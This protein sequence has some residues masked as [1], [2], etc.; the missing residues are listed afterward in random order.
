MT[1]LKSFLTYLLLVISVVSLAQNKQEMSLQAFNKVNLQGIM[2]VELVK[3]AANKVTAEALNG[4]NIEDLTVSVAG[5]ELSVKTKIFKQLTDK[6]QKKNNKANKE[7]KVK[8]EYTGDLTVLSA[9]RGADV[10][11][12]NIAANRLSIEASS[13]AIVESS[14]SVNALEIS[15][16][17]GAKVV[18]SGKA[19][20][21]Q[22]KV[23]TGGEL[24]AFSLNS[25]EIEVRANTGG[26]AQVNASKSLDASAATGGVITYKGSPAQRNVKSSLGGE[27]HSN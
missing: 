27:V 6:D 9:G 15:S 23:N 19:S 18:L 16:T 2:S 12:K 10:V 22:A 13:G 26:I 20:F 8:I 21:Q 24:E 3:G 5:G 17:Q 11:A 7:F 14:I 1:L 4:A 25:E